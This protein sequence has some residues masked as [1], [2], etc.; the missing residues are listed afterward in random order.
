MANPVCQAHG[1]E[2]S[3]GTG[4]TSSAYSQNFYDFNQTEGSFK[5]IITDL[6]VVERQMASLLKT[7]ESLSPSG[8]NLAK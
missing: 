4:C 2:M 8:K 7:Y 6:D 3:D 5:S 1:I